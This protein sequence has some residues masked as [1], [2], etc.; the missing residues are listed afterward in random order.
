MQLPPTVLSLDS[1]RRKDKA[2]A[3]GKGKV[4]NG[5]V[6]T[7]NYR[8][9]NDPHI[10]RPRS[11]RIS[12]ALTPKDIVSIDEILAEETALPLPEEAAAPAAATAATSSSQDS[13]AR[14]KHRHH[15]HRTEGEASSHRRKESDRRGRERGE[16]ERRSRR[17]APA[18]EEK[19]PRGFFGS[20]LR[21]F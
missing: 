21:G 11:R 12:S 6:R 4:E 8:S 17:S 3:S 10:E 5:P 18:P 9:R 7:S 19:K 2:A 16:G 20:L 1:N 14:R 13:S 15:R